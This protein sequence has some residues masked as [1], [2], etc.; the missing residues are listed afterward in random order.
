MTT[1]VYDFSFIFH[2]FLKTGIFSCA[3]S[4]KAMV[5]CGSALCQRSAEMLAFV[6]EPVGGG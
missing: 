5:G 3:V 1:A 6:F 4:P 2:L